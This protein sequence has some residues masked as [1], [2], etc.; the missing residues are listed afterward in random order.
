MFFP[1]STQSSERFRPMTSHAE[2]RFSL[3]SA[4]L[5]VSVIGIALGLARAGYIDIPLLICL[6]LSPVVATRLLK[7][8]SVFAA[9]AGGIV[10]AILASIVLMSARAGGSINSY[11]LPT[12]G[13][14]FLLS[15]SLALNVGIFVAIVRGAHN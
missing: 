11:D 6:F 8:P 1:L 5:G 3:L 13:E 12:N 4:L 10:G 15:T 9:G 2:T 14:L 7:W